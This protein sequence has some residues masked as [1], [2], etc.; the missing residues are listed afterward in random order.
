MQM[1]LLIRLRQFQPDPLEVWEQHENE[2]VIC[3]SYQT[4]HSVCVCVEEH[5]SVV[6]HFASTSSSL[7]T[8][9]LG[10]MDKIIGVPFFIPV[11]NTG[12]LTR[13]ISVD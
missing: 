3:L 7:H 8:L 12:W 13:G 6:R 1:K 2:M 10:M 5:V 4:V 9:N 11:S